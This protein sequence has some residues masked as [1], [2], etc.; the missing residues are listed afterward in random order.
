[1]YN[2]DGQGHRRARGEAKYLS[3]WLIQQG[4][5]LSNSALGGLER[6]GRRRISGRRLSGKRLAAQRPGGAAPSPPH[7]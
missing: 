3:A 7:S 4:V 5:V 1:M 6:G 2:K